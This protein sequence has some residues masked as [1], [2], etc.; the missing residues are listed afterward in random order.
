M[1]CIFCERIFLTDLSKPS[2]LIL[3]TA[4]NPCNVK[5]HI[6]AFNQAYKIVSIE[7]KNKISKHLYSLFSFNMG[8]LDAFEGDIAFKSSYLYEMFPV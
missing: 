2:R 3:D 5:Q 7:F 4:G 8:K 6:K 1:C